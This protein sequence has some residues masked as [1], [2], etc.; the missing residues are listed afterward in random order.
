M[1]RYDDMRV[2]RLLMKEYQQEMDVCLKSIVGLNDVDVLLE[3][4]EKT[5]AQYIG[6]KRA[7]A[8]QSGSDALRLALQVLGV[9]K[10]DSVIIPDVT[11]PAV[12]LSVLYAGAEPIVVDVKDNLQMN[13]DLIEKKIQ[14]NTKAIIGVHMFARPC[15]IEKIMSIARQRGLKVIEDCCQAE[16]ST[17]YQRK[18][19]SFAD[20]SCFSFSYYKPLSSCAGGGGMMC[21]NEDFYQDLMNYTRVWQDHSSQILGGQR[22]SR[23]SLMDLVVLR[24]K[25]KYLAQI[26]KTRKQ[27]QAFYEQQL[28]SID[29]IHVFKDEENVCSVPQNIIIQSKARDALGSFLSQQN[30]IWQEPY[31]PLHRM[32]NFS[33]FCQDAYPVAEQYG[34]ETIHLPLYS[35]MKKEDISY[36]CSMIKKYFQL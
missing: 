29:A 32:K 31:Q 2:D 15:S 23:M 8:L 19:G 17:F 34:L 33:S 21:F 9:G 10:G 11:Y 7:F 3:G 20:I 13:E 4:F 16:S 30:I 25:W 26:I 14:K 12:P 18:L 6:T 22:Y 28:A 5:F 35:F 27:S 36:I 24:V 1:I